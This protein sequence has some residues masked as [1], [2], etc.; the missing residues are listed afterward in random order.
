MIGV[1]G[2]DVSVAS[3][4]QRTLIHVYCTPIFS[5]VLEKSPCP[6][7]FL[8]LEDQL[9]SSCPLALSRVVFSRGDGGHV[10]SLEPPL[11]LKIQPNAPFH[12]EYSSSWRSHPHRWFQSQYHPGLKS[13]TTTLETTIQTVPPT[14]H[15]PYGTQTLQPYHMWS[16][17][18]QDYFFHI[19]FI[20]TA[21]NTSS[22]LTYVS[23]SKTSLCDGAHS[24][25]H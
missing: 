17:Y 15:L 10:P 16:K 12:Y 4:I 1:W 23:D 2:P 25:V 19:L 14:I 11:P 20:R 22:Q 9:T 5:V 3:V 18:V 21:L 6:Q 7:G 8:D 24:L 13:L